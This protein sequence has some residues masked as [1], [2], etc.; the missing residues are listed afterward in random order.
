MTNPYVGKPDYQFWKR[1]GGHDRPEAFDPVTHPSFAIK[2]S[3]SVV[4][5]GSC[6]AQHV[7]RHLTANGFNVLVTENAHPLIPDK[8]AADFHYGMFSARYGNVYTARQLRQLLERSY[9][10]FEPRQ[11]AWKFGKNRWVDPFRPQ[12][13]PGG[14]VSVRELLMDQDI[15]FR[16][17]RAAVERMTVFVFTLGLTEAWVDSKDGAVY[18]LAP[19]V[20]GGDYD[21]DEVK[22]VNFN[23]KQTI[24]DLE[25]SIGFI[26]R[27]NPLVK[28]ILTVSPVPLNATAVDRHVW[29]STT[30]SKATLRVAAEEVSNGFR[31]VDYFPSYEIITSPHAGGAYFEADHRSVTEAGVEHVMRTFLRHYGD[32]NPSKE[33]E[34]STPR[35]RAPQPAEDVREASRREVAAM[36]KI[37]QILCDEEAIDNAR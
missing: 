34:T 25:W 5:A 32:T 23:A 12:I 19:G 26:R 27:Q 20:A 14:Y 17:V 1:G 4:T 22:F 24:E 9:G 2:P 28:C 15:H 7:A 13:Q 31:H 16:A 35:E 21:P 36:S 3:D 10:L 11:K 29:V 6:F 30:Y 8:H 37:V 18:P 33:V